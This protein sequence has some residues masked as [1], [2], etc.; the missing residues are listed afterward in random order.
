M[1]RPEVGVGLVKT[2]RLSACLSSTI[3]ARPQ[4]R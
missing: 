1:I 4:T 3:R 2:E